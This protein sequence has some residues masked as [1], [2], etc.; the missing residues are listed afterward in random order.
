MKIDSEKKKGLKTNLSI[1]ID[2]KEIQKKMDERLLQLQSEVT[3]KGFRPGKVPPDVIK[4]QFGKAIYGEVI[5]KVLKETSEKAIKEKKI[6]VAGQP[7]INLKTFGEGKDL[8]YTLEV[9]SFPEFKLKPLDSLK[10]TE[11]KIKIEPKILDEK[12]TE[13]AKNQKKFSEK[14]DGEKSFKND[15]IVFDYEAT[16]EGN[17]FEGSDG[18]NVQIVLGQNL[19]LKGFDEQ[20]IGVKKGDTKTVEAILPPNYPKKELVNKK[21]K[22]ICKILNI[23]KADKI[24]IDD[25]FAKNLGAKNLTDLK[26]LL[27]KQISVQYKQALDS[28][29]KQQI[30]DQ[31]EKI[32][33]FDLPE[34]LVSHELSNMTQNL[35]QED[36][37]KHKKN[38]E[39]IASNRI[40]LSLILNE[41]GVKFNVK[42]SEEEIKGE[43]QKQIKSMPQQE[44]M[45]IEYYK[46]N[47]QALQSL[48]GALYE[49]KI[50]SSIKNKMK[51]ETREI[52]SNQAE[53]IISD[54]NKPKKNETLKSQEVKKSSQD[55]LKNKQKTKKISKK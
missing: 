44:K 25:N 37:D 9:D 17:K 53:K 41:Y 33:S 29:T 18:K 49:D 27:S 34:G 1:I 3:L 16:V 12:I 21:A 20:L 43:V 4:S 15:L 11:Y 46:K 26:N 55:T 5:D 30:L 38:N 40:K 2:K 39:K 50:I 48:R 45:V 8:S 36:K 47:P 13:L 23:K 19:F 42:V 24:K 31:L 32:Y 10:S 14:K 6:K 22:F 7:K 51:I 35:K 28:I 54:F 52:L